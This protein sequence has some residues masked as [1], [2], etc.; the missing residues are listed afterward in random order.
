MSTSDAIIIGGGLFGQ[1]IAKAL[2]S[3]GLKP[4]VI[5]AKLEGAGSAPAACL[6]KP[7]WL[8]SMGS[9]ATTALGLLDE[10]YG[11]QT[12]E[13]DLWPTRA[14]VP[15][16]WVP[17]KDILSGP[18]HVG[19]VASVIRGGVLMETGEEYRAPLTIVAAGIWTESLVPK[20]KQV[21]QTGISFLFPTQHSNFIKPGWMPYKQIVGFNRGDGYW[22][23][24]GSAIVQK[25]WG[26]HREIDSEQRCRLAISYWTNE[27]S[28]SFV[29]NRPY[30]KGQPFVL[31][32]LGPGYWV[33][34]GGAKNGTVAAAH[35]AR[36]IREKV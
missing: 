30:A 9:N 1:I 11:L 3:K 4:L 17:P 36:V 32:E 2:C 25:N 19:R 29:G 8:G 18:V 10:L 20:I 16:H 27:G 34:S 14:K 31:E 28:R 21:A 13:F 12:L 23:G 7:S 33:A 22:M 24:D 6:M 35:C 15:V 5:D 26:L